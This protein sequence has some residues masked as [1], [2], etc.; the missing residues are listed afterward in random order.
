MST[1][2]TASIAPDPRRAALL[3]SG[4]GTLTFLVAFC[5]IV[6]ELVFSQALSVMFGQTVVRYSVTI[7]LYLFSLGLGA[8]F[9]SRFRAERAA[10]LF[11][12]TEVALAVLGPMGVLGILWVGSSPGEFLL[13]ASGQTFLLLASHLPVVLVG[14]L[15]GLEIPLLALLGAS[16]RRALALVLGWDYLG[17]LAGAVLWGTWMYPRFGLLSAAL[18]I[19]LLNFVAAV[20][21]FMVFWRRRRGWVLVNLAVAAGYVWLTLGSA[22]MQEAVQRRYLASAI[23][24]R[25]WGAQMAAESVEVLERFATPYQEVVKYKLRMAGGQET[26]CLDLDLGPQLCDLW[27]E[28]Y[29]HGLVDVPMTALV[30]GGDVRVLVL[31]GGDFVAMR[32][33]QKYPAVVGVTLVDIDADFM[34][35]AR[36][37]AWVA[38]FH[39]GA[40]SDPRLR[41]VVDDA[42]A[43]LR[44]NRQRFELILYDLP[45]AHHDKLAHLFSSEAF[46]LMGRALSPGGVVVL[47]VPPARIAPAHLAVLRATLQHAGLRSVAAYDAKEGRGGRFWALSREAADLAP[48]GT[49]SATAAPHWDELVAHPDIRPHSLFA[50]NLA[51]VMSHAR[52]PCPRALVERCP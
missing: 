45:G 41:V 52:A 7:G 2:G 3:R 9:S 36:E 8:F 4:L 32:H 42:L 48:D 30:Q 33:L 13:S 26:M 14:I 19:G 47:E 16:E 39:G 6:Y 38:G 25:A 17:S 40:F 23:L 22:A 28:P 5:S 51:I 15:S 44:R 21:F 34:R 37:D 11:Y 20:A 35:F 29:H 43:F 50:P 31:G 46:G 12:A 49:P 1:A 18:G 24:E 10:L 27:V